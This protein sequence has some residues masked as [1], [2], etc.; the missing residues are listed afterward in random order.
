MLPTIFAGDNLLTAVSVARECGMIASEHRAIMLRAYLSPSGLPLTSF[1]LLGEGHDTA[2][3]MSSG[4]S[5]EGLGRWGRGEG[6]KKYPQAIHA[7]LLASLA[8]ATA[9]SFACMSTATS[10]MP[11]SS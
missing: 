2:Q 6:E 1:H 7:A 5:G 10:A 8:S 11:G 9:F 3:L 4:S